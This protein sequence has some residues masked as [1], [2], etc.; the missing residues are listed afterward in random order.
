MTMNE[1]GPEFTGAQDN[2]FESLCG[3]TIAVLAACLA[4]TDLGAGKYG[5]DELIAHNDKNSAYLWFQAKSIKETQVEGQKLA[6]ETLLEGGVIAAEHRASTEALVAK[7]QEKLDTYKREKTEILLGSKAV[8]ESNWVQDVDGQFGQVIGAK[9][10]ELIAAELGNAGDAFDYAC[11]FLQ[12]C[13]VFGAIALVLKAPRTKQ[14]FL[15]G[16]VGLGLL[17]IVLS[18]VAFRTALAL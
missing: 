9:Q 4:I 13:L 11:L 18:V 7:L 14:M 8:G 2:R 5:D 6:V 1:S 12:L 15:V 10:Y 3:V 17:G 16:M